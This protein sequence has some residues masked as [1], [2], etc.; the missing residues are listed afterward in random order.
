[1]N[2]KKILIDTKTIEYLEKRNLWKQFKKAKN[3][4]LNWYFKSVDF[5]LKKPKEARVYYFRI[6]KQ[7]RA[8]GFVEN[9]IFKV[10]SIDNHQ[11]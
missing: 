3:L 10:K 8:I 2:I 9:N 4:L 7:F 11:D 5:K 1:M 6:N